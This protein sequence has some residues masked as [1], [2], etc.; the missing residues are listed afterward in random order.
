M[1]LPN[2]LVRLVPNA[3]CIRCGQHGY[4]AEKAELCLGCL[5]ISTLIYAK[6]KKAEVLK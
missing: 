3:T 2:L 5:N 6:R 4:V 1:K